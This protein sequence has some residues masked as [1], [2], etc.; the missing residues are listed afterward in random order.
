MVYQESVC[1]EGALTT[2]PMLSPYPFSQIY[3]T[4][5]REGSN[6]Y[7]CNLPKNYLAEAGLDYSN[8]RRGARNGGGVSE[9]D[10]KETI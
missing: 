10:G 1:L 2:V 6:P 4:K 3:I 9:G 8:N 5:A 7:R